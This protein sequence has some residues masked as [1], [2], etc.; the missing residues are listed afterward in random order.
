MGR[1][2][3]G[4]ICDISRYPRILDPHPW[5]YIGMRQFIKIKLFLQLFFKNLRSQNEQRLQAPSSP[6]HAYL[7]LFNRHHRFP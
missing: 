2:N 6:E 3:P 5:I 1:Q 4:I 7:C